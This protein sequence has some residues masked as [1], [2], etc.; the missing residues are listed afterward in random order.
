MLTGSKHYGGHFKY[1]SWR[2]TEFNVMVTSL[3]GYV[4]K[5]CGSYIY[6]DFFTL[7]LECG[8]WFMK[9]IFKLFQTSYTIKLN[10]HTTR[11]ISELS[12]MPQFLN[13]WL[14]R[15]F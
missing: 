4:I 3:V 6:V 5:D 1:S 14:W 12:S 8:I 13:W 15:L 2:H 10:C 7:N 11:W 9:V